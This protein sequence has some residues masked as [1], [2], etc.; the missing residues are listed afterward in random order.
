MNTAPVT[1]TAG[2]A[3]RARYFQIERARLQSCQDLALEADTAARRLLAALELFD[4]LDEAIGFEQAGSS[5]VHGFTG[6]PIPWLQQRR[7]QAW[8]ACV[9]AARHLDVVADDLAAAAAVTADPGRTG[10]LA[11]G[12]AALAAEARRVVDSHGPGRDGQQVDWARVD[13][14]TDGLRRVHALDLADA[15]RDAAATVEA[16]D[17]RRAEL[18]A[19][20]M[21]GQLAAIDTDQGLQASVRQLRALAVQ[22]TTA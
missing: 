6:H 3:A 22:G 7:G 2:E 11:R 1:T 15:C 16:F 17:R 18:Q 5:I 21:G 12:Y 4:E 10:H 14:I 9:A 20:G 8:G 19:M 13:G